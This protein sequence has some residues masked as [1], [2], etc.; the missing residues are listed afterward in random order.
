MRFQLITNI[1]E[2]DVFMEVRLQNLID[3]NGM[4]SPV[5]QY[6][7]LYTVSCSTSIFRHPFGFPHESGTFGVIEFCRS[8]HRIGTI[9]RKAVIKYFCHCF[10]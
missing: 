3:V 1:E 6:N 2:Y 9:L 10:C 4:S 5:F 8:L 7:S